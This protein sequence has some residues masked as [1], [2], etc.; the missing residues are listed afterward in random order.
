M[1]DYNLKY[2]TERKIKKRMDQLQE[3]MESNYHLEHPDE[4][5]ELVDSVSKFWSAIQDEDKD[6][7]HG[8]RYALEEK[9]EWGN[10]NK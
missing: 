8:I 9:L 7:I 2:P 5:E 1:T 4:V 10:P 6:Y 3:W